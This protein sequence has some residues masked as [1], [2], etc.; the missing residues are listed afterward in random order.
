MKLAWHCRSHQ[1]ALVAIC[2]R[3]AGT[4]ICNR[5]LAG[6]ICNCTDK[7]VFVSSTNAT[8]LE[9][10]LL[11]SGDDLYRLALLLSA[12]ESGAAQ[13]LIK[14][15]R[16]LATSGSAPE[17]LALITALLQSLPAERRRLR[18]RRLPVWA[19]PGAASA[20][21]AELLAALAGLPRT[22]RFALGLTMLRSFEST[23][24]ALLLGDEGRIGAVQEPGLA[25]EPVRVAVD[26][27]R[28][29]VRDALLA[30]APVAIPTVSPA[31]LDSDSA[32]EDCRPTR[33][34]LA[35]N[36]P[37]LHHDAAIRGHLALCSACRAAEQAWQSLSIAVEEAL[38]GALR[39]T[40]L[41]PTLADQLQVAIQPAPVAGWALLSSPRA[42]LA[43]VALPVLALIAFLVWPRGT[44]PAPTASAPPL[45]QAPAARE[46]VQRA[47][48][49][50]YLPPAGQGVWHGRYEV[51]WAFADDTMALLAGDA[52]ID[53]ASGRH[54]IQLVHHSGGGPYEFELADGISSTSYAISNIYQPSLYLLLNNQLNRVKVEATPEQQNRMLAARFQSGAWGIAS[55]YLRQATQA[56]LRTWG[57]QRDVDG[58][59]LDL[60]S[61]SGISPLALPADAPNATT[62]RVTVL[63]AINEASGRLREVRELIGPTGSEQTTRITW[64][65]V[66]EEWIN[67]DQ[68][69]SHVFDLLEA[70]NGVGS[71]TAIGKLVDP[72][73]PLTRAEVV[74]ALASSY[75]LGWT[76]LWMPASA[77]PD[78]NAAFLLTYGPPQIRGNQPD[79]A[80]RLTFI[81]LAP[82]HRLEISTAP[83]EG[84][85]PPLVGGEIVLLDQRQMLIRPGNGRRYQAQINHNLGNIPGTTVYT[86]QV[87]AFGYTRAE[88]L[89]VLR[90]LGPPSLASYAA[91][92]R[93]FADPGQHDSAAFDAL[94]TALA[95]ASVGAIP[96][97]AGPPRH[98]VERVFKRQDQQPDGLPD[99]YHRPRYSGWPAQVIQDNWVRGED[100]PPAVERVAITKGDDGTL[101]GRQYLG[102][103]QV[104]YYDALASH[105]KVYSS[106]LIDSEQRI[107]ED[108]SM[109]MRLIICGAGTLQTSANGA[110]TIV[111]IEQNWR[112]G[113][114]C[115]H[116]EYAQ[117]FAAQSANDANSDPDQTPFLADRTEAEL[118]TLVGLNAAGRDV[119][120][121]TWAGQPA[122]GTLLQSWELISDEVVPPARIPAATFD[123]TPPDALQR[124]SY[125]Q[126]QP[127]R[128]V[129]SNVTITQALALAQT[130]LFELLTAQATGVITNTSQV[131]VTITPPF[132]NSIIAGP[133]PNAPGSHWDIDGQDV[134]DQA[135][136]DGYAIR[137]SY[138]LTAADGS[139]QT[140]NLY[141]WSAQ[142][143]GAYLR[144]SAKWQSSSA[145]TIT[146]GDKQVHG[147]RVVERPNDVEWL[148]FELD[149]TLI[150]AESPSD[151]LLAALGQLRAVTR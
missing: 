16:Q 123:A 17:Q 98:F 58:A 127:V 50:L 106:A 71:F 43:L 126:N 39:D 1:N 124:W 60:V 46:L 105:V 73:L 8:E 110:R 72:A 7:G 63:L 34:A 70:W 21:R 35:L 86:T 42:R 32:P 117:F 5:V 19:R 104:W 149:G 150:A 31:L 142:T 135:L 6:R 81:Y 4:R 96:T 15:V 67:D 89:A 82:G 61:F 91:Q 125:Q 108:Q 11:R 30:L 9:R 121:Q 129:P 13:A 115:M 24:I 52:W 59:L 56:E 18:Q 148:L 139:T 69:S 143:L 74:T 134:F 14:A 47:R 84:A 10:T 122:T 113:G 80:T 54:R 36:D 120:I 146:I 145:V 136:R 131:T 112:T 107:N 141:Q 12:D 97:Q 138:T 62:S 2:K 88:L 128:P 111:L 53:S 95:P 144:A 132:L 38:R 114:S 49:Q 130:P 64:R 79:A 65:Q 40:R 92:A 109:L 78:T 3:P 94:L 22:Q 76:G 68:T 48:D 93:L 55:D 20:A 87:A 51:Q 90:T 77:P 44:P 116:P 83:N 27:A 37:A 25:S 102:P 119:K 28:A 41:P 118:T 23:Q 100:Q 140:A 101:Y 99:P 29:V 26:Q 133:P 151:E 33:A 45:A 147:W 85:I 66:S 75:Q 103:D 137:V 57:R